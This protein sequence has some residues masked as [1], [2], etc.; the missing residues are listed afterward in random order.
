MGGRG[1]IAICGGVGGRR[2]R[3]RGGYDDGGARGP[4]LRA[5]LSLLSSLSTALPFAYPRSPACDWNGNGTEQAHPHHNPKSPTDH[6]SKPMGQR[7]VRSRTSQH[8]HLNA[9]DTQPH[10]GRTVRGGGGWEVKLAPRACWHGGG[11]TPQTP[12]LWPVECEAEVLGITPTEPG[13]RLAPG[14]RSYRRDRGA[15]GAQPFHGGWGRLGAAGGIKGQR[16]VQGG[17]TLSL[18]G[19]PIETNCK[20]EHAPITARVGQGPV[21]GMGGV[22]ECQSNNLEESFHCELKLWEKERQAQLY[23]QNWVGW[24]PGSSLTNL[25]NPHPRAGSERPTSAAELTFEMGSRLD[26]PR[27]Y[28]CDCRDELKSPL[29]GLGQALVVTWKPP[30]GPRKIW[31]V[32]YQMTA[33]SI[34]AQAFISGNR[35]FFQTNIRISSSI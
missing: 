8:M 7:S 26:H 19:A 20:L 30:G 15:M 28:Q 34:L 25:S 9:L 11:N 13:R 14:G 35:A 17:C 1:G 24:C 16:R 10:S 33:G 5:P 23:P 12:T 6:M 27:S 22:S 21:D 32:N 31:R 2:K 3:W 29:S 4:S 18:P